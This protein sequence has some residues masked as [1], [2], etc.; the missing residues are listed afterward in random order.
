[1]V[2]R[3]ITLLVSLLGF[4]HAATA[5]ELSGELVLRER[6]ALP[7]S[8]RAM[9]VVHDAAGDR[10]ETLFPLDGRQPPVAFS[11]GVSEG[12]VLV[13]GAIHLPD[14]PTYVTAPVHQG[15][16][17]ESATLGEM[18][19]FPY[20]RMGFA[21]WLSCGPNLV[22]VGFLDDSAVLFH[23]GQS[24]SLPPVPAASG[25]RF[26]DGQG[27]ALHS[28][29]DRVSVIWHGESWPECSA[30]PHPSDQADV[31]LRGEDWVG[32]L[33][34]AGVILSIAGEPPM[35]ANGRVDWPGDSR[36]THHAPGLPPVTLSPGLC[37]TGENPL[38]FPARA[39][40][41]TTPARDGCAGD[42]LTLL[43]GDWRADPS[44]LPE[45]AELTLSFDGERYSGK[46]V[47]NR[48]FG[49]LVVGPDTVQFGRSGSTMMA[50]P[51]NWMEAER[52]WHET[53]ARVT[54][55]DIDAEGRLF[56]LADDEVI[57]T[58]ARE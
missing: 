21:S 25:S 47:C 56:L 13:Q 24:V 33:G 57:A 36:L 4:A 28:K 22:S 41:E 1:M 6:I 58:L 18:R 3:A 34:P 14:G 51:Q 5:R 46:S 29:G 32:T 9:I 17:T 37:R 15:A 26:E 12:S 31:P 27:H 42:P 50:C 40:L 39:R 10:S 35:T 45:G 20:P 16:G 43:Q 52:A 48:Y 38:P 23:N 2:L 55:F 7:D 30:F 44:G 8:A 54:A 19:L 49:S 11:V 53:L